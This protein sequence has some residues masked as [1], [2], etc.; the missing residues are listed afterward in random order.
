MAEQK[1][2]KRNTNTRLF[3]IVKKMA[4]VEAQT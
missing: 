1:I 2:V 4:F 3:V